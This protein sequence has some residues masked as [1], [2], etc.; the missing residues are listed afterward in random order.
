MF[1][2]TFHAGRNLYP[3]TRFIPRRTAISAVM[4][5]KTSLCR[6]QNCRERK[7]VRAFYLAKGR[8]LAFTSPSQLPL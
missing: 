8:W 3:Y 6:R 2:F 4:K 7:S 1:R 5:P